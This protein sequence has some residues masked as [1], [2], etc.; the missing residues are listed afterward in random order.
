MIPVHLLTPPKPP[1]PTVTKELSKDIV[2]A[3]ELLNDTLH[4]TMQS[5][6]NHKQAL[7]QREKLV[8]AL[9]LLANPPFFIEE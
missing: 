2:A 6:E 3:I 1:V 9:F 5:S 4:N 8:E 7:Q